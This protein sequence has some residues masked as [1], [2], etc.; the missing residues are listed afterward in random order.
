MRRLQQRYGGTTDDEITNGARRYKISAI[1]AL[2]P[3]VSA[4]IELHNKYKELGLVV[5]NLINSGS[6]SAHLYA[7]ERTLVQQQL[8][9]IYTNHGLSDLDMHTHYQEIVWD[10]LS[11]D[12]VARSILVLKP[13]TQNPRVLKACAYIVAAMMNAE[14]NTSIAVTNR[15]CLDI[16][17]G[18]GALIPVLSIF[19]QSS[20]IYGIDIS[21]EMIKYARELYPHCHFIHGDFSR[22]HPSSHSNRSENVNSGVPEEDNDDF[23]DNIIFSSSMPYIPNTC[24][25]LEHAISLMRPNGTGIIVL[26][27]NNGAG[28]VQALYSVQ[29]SLSTQLLPSAQ[30]LRTFEEDYNG[31]QIDPISNVAK[32]TRTFTATTSTSN[33]V[34][35]LLVEP[36]APNSPQDESEGYVAVLQV[37]KG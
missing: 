23:Y 33:T 30:E 13:T 7:H 26:Y 8:Q 1:A 11:Y 15:R 20:Q 4:G 3:H 27:H 18:F 19:I 16:G 21:G 10:A 34:L 2:P 17:C 29:R 5:S 28:E 9:N 31:K 14:N 35:H 24:Q 37:Q 25:V 32:T 6:P 22:Y 36:A 12:M